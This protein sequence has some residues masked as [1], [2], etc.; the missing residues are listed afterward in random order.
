[1]FMPNIT[2]GFFVYQLVTAILWRD[3]IQKTWSLYRMVLQHKIDSYSITLN[4]H[5][6]CAFSHC[7]V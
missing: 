7:C 1:M 3:E 6:V 2:L 5:V 4:A